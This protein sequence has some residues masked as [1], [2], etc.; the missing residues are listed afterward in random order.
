MPNPDD[1][2]LTTF[3]QAV[4]QNIGSRPESSEQF[5]STISQGLAD[6]GKTLQLARGGLDAENGVPRRLRVLPGEK[7]VEARDVVQRFG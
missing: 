1:Y 5:S 3:L 2:R 4:A 7:I 6:L